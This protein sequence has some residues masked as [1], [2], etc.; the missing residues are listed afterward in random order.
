M[1]SIL[2]YFS[3][4]MIML[5]AEFRNGFSYFLSIRFNHFNILLFPASLVLCSKNPS[6]FLVH[7]KARNENVFVLFLY[8]VCT[9]YSVS[10]FYLEIEIVKIL[11]KYLISL[12]TYFFPFTLLSCSDS[13]CW[14]AGSLDSFFN[15][16]KLYLLIFIFISFIYCIF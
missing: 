8:S 10:P 4:F 3:T 9:G 13:Y 16:F 6:I 5:F 11:W 14:D 15:L 2:I 1:P 7:R 12:I